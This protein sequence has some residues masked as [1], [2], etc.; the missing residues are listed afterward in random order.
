MRALSAQEILKENQT[1]E[2]FGSFYKGL[3]RMEDY[4]DLN[5][6]KQVESDQRL[7]Q[8][9]FIYQSGKEL[10]HLALEAPVGEYIKKSLHKFI[11]IKDLTTLAVHKDS[12]GKLSINSKKNSGSEEALAWFKLHVSPKR[13]LEPRLRIMNKLTLSYDFLESAA[14]IEFEADF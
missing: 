1:Y 5:L 9:V 10:M 2:R 7:A 13:G 12:E 6:L 14:L 4:L 3:V 11:W 8:S